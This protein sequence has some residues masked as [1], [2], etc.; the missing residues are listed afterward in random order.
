MRQE[1]SCLVNGG[2]VES[3]SRSSSLAWKYIDVELAMSREYFG[4]VEI[5]G[6]GGW[7]LSC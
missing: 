5:C 6:K 3:A 4:H 1:T 7:R 2:N